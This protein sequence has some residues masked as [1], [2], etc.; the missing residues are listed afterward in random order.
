MT[1][2]RLYP[3]AGHCSQA[4]ARNK[5]WPAQELVLAF[6]S[7]LLP[8]KLS[9]MMMS[10]PLAE[11]RHEGQSQSVDLSAR[12]LRMGPPRPGQD[13]AFS[14]LKTLRPLDLRP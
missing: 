11:V 2:F 10:P 9:A 1:P 12:T 14:D 5:T 6:L 3:A 7:E 8:T 13:E 4:F